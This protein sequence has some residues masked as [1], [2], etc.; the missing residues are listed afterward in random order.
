MNFMI[1]V[2]LWGRSG[3]K[4]WCQGV[5][6]DLHRMGWCPVLTFDTWKN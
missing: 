2:K 1:V 6:S 4:V 3:V 5:V